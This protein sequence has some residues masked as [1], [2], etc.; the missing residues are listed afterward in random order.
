MVIQAFVDESASDPV[1]VMGGYSATAER[2]AAFS[3]AWG[4]ELA[5]EPKLAYFKTK[6]AAS[7]SGC[8]D[9]FTPDQRDS[10]VSNF[11]KI[12]NDHVLYGFAVGVNDREYREVIKGK[13]SCTLDSP[14]FFFRLC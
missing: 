5:R 11:V 6:E 4:A 1:F 12:I 10:R 7:R 3:E 14:Y 2:W 13:S 9:I 8:F